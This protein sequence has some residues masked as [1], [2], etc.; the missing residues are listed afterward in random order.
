M[1][2]LSWL[3]VTLAGL[4][5]AVM[6]VSISVAQRAT[7]EARST[8]FPIVREEETIRARR[9]RIAS[10]L[11]GVIAAIM[12]GAFFVSGHYPAAPFLLPPQVPGQ[13]V[14]LS[15]SSSTQEAAPATP[16]PPPQ[17]EAVPTS[18]QVQLVTVARPPTGSGAP[19]PTAPATTAPPTS[20]APP[21]TATPVLD[22]PT[23]T[24]PPATAPSSAQLGPI[25]F[26]LDIT[27][28]REPVTSTSVFSDTVARVYASFPYAGMTDG[29]NWSHVWYF[30]GVEYNRGEEEWQWGNAD[31]SYVF[32]RVVGAGEYR[33]ELYVNDDLLAS[34]EF[35][36]QGPAAI[37]G[38][39]GSGPETIA[40]EAT[41]GGQKPE[42]GVASPESQ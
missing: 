42:E 1:S 13:A 31:R 3:L 28:D 36:V 41:P 9:A 26:T 33:L 8:I 22:T 16:V 25:D 24:R 2:L 29:I 15:A 32:T 19:A 18:S 35:L 37:G 27:D 17:E 21:V 14:A 39:A 4:S 38:P 30:N 6:V 12:A 20:T 11:T 40:E 34:G 10:S 7:R 5:L 23:P